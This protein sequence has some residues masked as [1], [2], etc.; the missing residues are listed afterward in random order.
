MSPGI[1]LHHSQIPVCGKGWTLARCAEQVAGP[2]AE[3][4]PEPRCPVRV[5]KVDRAHGSSLPTAVILCWS[6][7]VMLWPGLGGFFSEGWHVFQLH[8]ANWR[9]SIICNMWYRLVGFFL[10][11][12]SFCLCTCIVLYGLLIVYLFKVVVFLGFLV[13]LAGIWCRQCKLPGARGQALLAGSKP[14][15]DV[16]LEG[17]LPALQSQWPFHWK[18]LFSYESWLGQ[19]VAESWNSGT[20]C[21]E[22]TFRGKGHWDVRPNSL[23]TYFHIINTENWKSRVVLREQ[24][25]L[26][27]IGQSINRRGVA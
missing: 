12:L 5:Q 23:F 2:A 18:C 24:N 3:V 22:S 25:R 27:T 11:F 9:L 17:C 20:V 19:H 10:L 14:S 15:R 26:G 8:I 1:V 4:V 21:P 7:R 16:S 13:G 6:W